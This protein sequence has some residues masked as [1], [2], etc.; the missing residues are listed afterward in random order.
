MNEGS[1]Q[2]VSPLYWA[3]PSIFGPKQSDV[4]FLFSFFLG[5]NCPIRGASL[6]MWH[7]GPAPVVKTPLFTTGNQI[8]CYLIEQQHPVLLR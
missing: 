6:L 7:C 1:F 2:F 5:R 8:G 3:G 4:I